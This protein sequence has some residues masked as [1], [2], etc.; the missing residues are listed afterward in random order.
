MYQ[1]RQVHKCH[2]YHTRLLTSILCLKELRLNK[3]T[4]TGEW[5]GG[6]EVVRGMYVE[7]STLLANYQAISPTRNS[8]TLCMKDRLPYTM[9]SKRPQPRGVCCWESPD[10]S[11]APASME[12]LRNPGFLGVQD[13]PLMW[14]TP[15]FAFFHTVLLPALNFC[16]S[17]A[18][19]SLIGLLD[20]KGVL[21]YLAWIS[22]TTFSSVPPHFMLRL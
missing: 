4:Q 10:P 19:S 5:L 13:L 3:Q 11:P 1:I 14:T 2:V 17:S 18:S 15:V 12:R 6:N 16:S 9:L 20:W 8:Q 21:W 7:F 22:Q